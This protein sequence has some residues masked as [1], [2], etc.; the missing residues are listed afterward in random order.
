MNASLVFKVNTLLDS[1]ATR[2]FIDK[3]FVKRSQIPKIALPRAELLAKI[4][5]LGGCTMILGHTW[6]HQHNPLIDWKT[7]KVRLGRCPARC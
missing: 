2:V 5:D 6:L 1:G 7:G 4:T 3:D